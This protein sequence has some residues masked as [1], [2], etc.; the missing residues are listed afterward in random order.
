VA[1]GAAMWGHTFAP[2]VLRAERPDRELAEPEEVL[3][4]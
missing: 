3:R 2:D 4:W 1:T